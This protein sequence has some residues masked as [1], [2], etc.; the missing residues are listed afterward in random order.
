MTTLKI[1]DNDLPYVMYDKLN[2][3]NVLLKKEKY[4]N[5]LKF[6]NEIFKKTNT[7]LRQFTNISCEFFINYK[8]LSKF[9]KICESH[10]EKLHIEFEKIKLASLKEIELEKTKKGKPVC[11]NESD[12]SDGSDDSDNDTNTKKNKKKE[13]NINVNREIFL[14]ISRLLKTIDYK[15]KRGTSFGKPC[16]SISV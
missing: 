8:E 9:V 13:K 12:D 16:Y 7:G 6:L 2:A 11:V 3:Y 15:L 1:N 4:A 14:L 10:K 5:I